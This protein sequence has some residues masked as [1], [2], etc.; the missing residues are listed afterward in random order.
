M[1]LTDRERALF[2]RA[3]EYVAAERLPRTVPKSVLAGGGNDAIC[4]LCDCAIGREQVEY[5]FTGDNGATYHLHMRC[6]ATW[7]LAASHG[8]RGD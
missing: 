6:H 1:P 2:A 3:R 5:E 4:S 7:Q 8:I